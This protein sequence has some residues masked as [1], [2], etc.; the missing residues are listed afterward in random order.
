MCE[1]GQG[2]TEEVTNVKAIIVAFMS[3]VEQMKS[4]NMSMIF[5]MV[6][7]PDVAVEPEMPQTTTKDDV[8]VEDVTDPESEAETDE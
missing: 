1:H 7:I 5:C 8:R 4:T 6:E 2:A 3:D